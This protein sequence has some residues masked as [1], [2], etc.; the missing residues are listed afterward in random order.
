MNTTINFHNVTDVEVNEIRT[1]E[2]DQETDTFYSRHITITDSN[3]NKTEIV[4]FSDNR[5]AVKIV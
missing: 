4:L 3:G 2:K 1:F 5:N